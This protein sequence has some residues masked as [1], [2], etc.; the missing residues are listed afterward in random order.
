[1]R[2]YF[3]S[4]LVKTADLDPTKPHLLLYHPHGIVS[5]GLQASLALSSCSFE[6]KYPGVRRSVATLVA[7]FKIPFFREWILMNGYISCGRSTLVAHARAG[8]SVVLVPGGAQEALHANPGA[9]KLHLLGRKGFVRVALAA[10]CGLVPCLG[11][12]ENEMFKCADNQSDEAKAQR[13]WK[14]QVYL[15][16]RFTFSLPVL[17]HVLPKRVKVAVVVG[18]PLEVP[19]VEDPRDEVVEK[20][21]KLYVEALRKL[22]E[23]HKGYY[24]NGVELEIV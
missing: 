13:L 16:K 15:M 4:E 14:G 21:H 5:M 10:G 20:Y 1:M 6:E 9:F 17:T 3:D 11:F 8:K 23:D 24:G 18:K 2:P 12:G 22:Y 7:S 19:K